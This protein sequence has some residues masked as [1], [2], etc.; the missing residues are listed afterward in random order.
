MEV[1]IG[2]REEGSGD[3]GC[4]PNT[5]RTNWD[6]GPPTLSQVY[7]PCIEW[8]G[9]GHT[10]GKCSKR[11]ALA[12]LGMHLSWQPLCIMGHPCN[13]SVSV[14]SPAGKLRCEPN[15]QKQSSKS[16][17]ESGAMAQKRTPPI[18]WHGNA[19]FPTFPLQTSPLP[20]KLPVNGPT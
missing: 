2:Q 5:F 10:I 19:G 9:W 11:P 3:P 6:G 20:R 15:A 12:L 18:F 16:Q 13:A 17:V 14:S 7:K 1:G 4:G 8:L